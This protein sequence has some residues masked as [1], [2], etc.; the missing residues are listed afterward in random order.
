MSQTARILLWAFTI[1]M[2]F[3]LGAG[4]YEARVNVA[5]WSRAIT[6]RT[7]DG[8]AYMR[9]APS[10]GQRW[11]MGL[12]PLLALVTIAALIAALRTTGPARPWMVWST[13]LQL[14][15]VIWTFAWFVPNI[16]N[17]MAHYRELPAELV[18]SRTTAWVS[19]NWVRAALTVTA[20]L[21]ALKAMTL[22]GVGRS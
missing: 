2:G 20:W 9:F 18:A 12:T 14:A 11:W 10:A 8:E 7:P 17:L 21:G 16:M 5:G 4:V 19:L 22:S 3:D 13:A 15:V 1:L 6:S